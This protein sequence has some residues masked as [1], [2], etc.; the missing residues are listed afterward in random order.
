MSYFTPQPTIPDRSHGQAAFNSEVDAYLNWQGINASEMAAF[1]AQVEPLANSYPSILASAA[2]KGNWSSLTGALNMPA[3]VYHNERLWF[4]TQN[5]ANVTTATPGVSS[6]WVGVKASTW[7]RLSTL[8]INGSPTSLMITNLP[9][10]YSDLSIVL[11][12]V[13]VAAPSSRTLNIAYSTDNGLSYG[14]ALPITAGMSMGNF[15]QVSG[16]HQMIGYRRGT[17]SSISIAGS[18]NTSQATGGICS[19]RRVGSVVNAIRLNFGD[20]AVFYAGNVYVDA[21]I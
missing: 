12:A 3:S 19:W 9:Q 6:A 17:V 8:V 4:L 13:Q 16:E 18:G 10:E 15:D 11:D 5:L 7:R 14:T 21:R 1:N 2:F 20:G